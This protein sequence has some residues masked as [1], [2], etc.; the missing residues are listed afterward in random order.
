M[1]GRIHIA[2]ILLYEIALHET[3]SLTQ[4]ERLS[5]LWRCLQSVVAYMRVRFAESD[6][7]RPKFI[8]LKAA[9]FV[10][11][12]QVGLRLYSLRTP[13]WDLEL[14]RE[15]LGIDRWIIEQAAELERILEARS[16]GPWT[17]AMQAAGLSPA[18]VDPFQKLLISLRGFSTL[19]SR[20]NEKNVL[21]TPPV[22][23]ARV[24]AQEQAQGQAQDE[25][26]MAGMETEMS[27]FD[28]FHLTQLDFMTMG[29][30]AP[31]W[32]Y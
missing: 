13:G 18:I 15:S 9:D 24:Q 30:P 22:D 17:K 6:I 5:L 1:N 4:P 10:F 29:A 19:V 27:L 28:D 2:E 11:A 20:E 32:E 14:V 26:F 12:I 3:P 16:Q 8:C 23:A 7:W 25:G 31:P 21:I